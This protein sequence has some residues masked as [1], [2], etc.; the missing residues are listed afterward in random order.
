LG[1][2]V[3]AR[4]CTVPLPGRTKA[5]ADTVIKRFVQEAL[6]VD[7]RK[8]LSINQLQRDVEPMVLILQHTIGNRLV[9]V[10]YD[11]Q[12]FVEKHLALLVNVGKNERDWKGLKVQ[13]VIV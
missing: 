12:D 8:S 4:N 6:G 9:Y 13:L 10:V 7:V 2:G 11:N 1:Q 3:T 5:M